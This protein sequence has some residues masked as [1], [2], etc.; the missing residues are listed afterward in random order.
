MC[1]AAVYQSSINADQFAIV[2]TPVRLHSAPK[3]VA[4]YVVGAA[5]S[6]AAKDVFSTHVM[7]GVDKLHAEGYFGKGIEIGII[8][9]GIDCTHPALGG[10]I[11]PANKVIGGYDFVG[12][13]YTGSAGTVDSVPDGDVSRFSIT[14]FARS[15]T[16]R[17]SPSC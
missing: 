6:N 12:G 8:G 1:L 13:A 16:Q 4:S 7:T 17:F 3:P 14:L 2:V 9:S 15:L 11:G 5:H 10:K